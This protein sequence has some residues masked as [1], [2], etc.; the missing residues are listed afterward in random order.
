[1]LVFKHEVMFST[2]I[3]GIHSR[4]LWDNRFFTCAVFTEYESPIFLWFINL[5][6]TFYELKIITIIRV[7]FV[8][9]L[10]MILLNI[11]VSAFFFVTPA[12]WVPILLHLR[13]SQLMEFDYKI[14][15]P[16]S[17]TWQDTRYYFTSLILFGHGTFGWSKIKDCIHAPFSESCILHIPIVRLF[18]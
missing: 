16:L 14:L 13:V 8:D 3:P 1:M 7:K 6:H 17:L 10:F 12:K 11:W 9:L 18:S 2:K 4:W 5:H 15:N